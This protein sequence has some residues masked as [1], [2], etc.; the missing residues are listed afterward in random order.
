M[1]V[2]AKLINKYHTDDLLSA[3]EELPVIELPQYP[4][5]EPV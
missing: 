1:I 4:F 5:I 2:L 3:V